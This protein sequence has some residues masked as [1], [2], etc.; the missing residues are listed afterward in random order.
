MFAEENVDN[1]AA[2]A[3]ATMDSEPMEEWPLQEETI[4]IMSVR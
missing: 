4:C 2:E 3:M 1:M